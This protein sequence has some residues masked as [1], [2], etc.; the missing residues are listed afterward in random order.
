MNLT[1]LKKTTNTFLI[2]NINR[3]QKLKQKDCLK[4]VPLKYVF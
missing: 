3:F 1:F 4:I 2:Q